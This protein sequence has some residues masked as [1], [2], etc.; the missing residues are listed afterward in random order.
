METEVSFY[1]Y[2]LPSYRVRVRHGQRRLKLKL[3]VACCT[4]PMAIRWATRT[5]ETGLSGEWQRSTGQ[6]AVG[7]AP[8]LFPNPAFAFNSA[9]SA[10][11]DTT[12]LPSE[13]FAS[14]AWRR[15]EAKRRSRIWTWDSNW[16]GFWPRL[17]RVGCIRI[18]QNICLYPHR[19]AQVNVS[20][21]EG[22]TRRKAERKWNFIIAK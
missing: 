11:A 3:T 19:T 14:C 20:E 18:E 17:I 8:T 22:R 5:L 15:V 12:W 1:F 13:R 6:G 9:G 4:I 2:A 16:F 10:V 21:Q 7:P